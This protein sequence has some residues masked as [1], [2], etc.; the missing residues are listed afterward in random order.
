MKILYFGNERLEAQRFAVALHG[1]AEHGTVSWTSSL[2]RAIKWLDE[3]PDVAALVVE[4]RIDGGTWASVLNQARRPGR[5]PA[6]VL[7]VPEGTGPGVRAMVPG[8]DEYVEKNSPQFLQLPQVVTRAAAASRN[9]H[10][11]SAGL[12]GPPASQPTAPARAPEP[13]RGLAA[14]TS[15]VNRASDSELSRS[16]ALCAELEQ[17]LA[18]ATAALKDAEERHAAAMAASAEQLAERQ[19]Q[20]ELAASR[21]AARWEMVDEQLRAAA[22]E[23]ES[24]RLAHAAAAAEVARL[25]QRESELTTRL[26]ESAA[27]H[28]ALEQR[29]AEVEA[30]GEAAHARSV[31]E[32]RTAAE[33][34]QELQAQIAAEVEARQQIEAALAQAVTARESAA[35]HAQRLDEALC[36]ARIAEASAA[37]EIE[38]FTR[39]EAELASL[40]DEARAAQRNVE[41][42]LA[43]TEAAFQDADVRATSDRLA[44][45]KKAAAREAELDAQ[46]RQERAVRAAL[47][48][49]AAD[50]EDQHQAALAAAAQELADRQ[51]QFDRQLSDSVAERERLLGRL[52]AVDQALAQLQTAHHAAIATADELS[53]R[54]AELTS[55]L[56]GSEVQLAA[57][58]ALREQL[59]SD[60]AATVAS[61]A[62]LTAQSA[63]LEQQI[64]WERT[65]RAALESALSDFE[66]MARET[67]LGYDAALAAAAH[68][69]AVR[70]ARF[71]QVVAGTTADRD[72]LA[73]QLTSLESAF[74]RARADHLAAV[75]EVARLT[76]RETELTTQIDEAG[77]VRAEIERQLREAVA[78]ATAVEADLRGQLTEER[79]TRA[80]VEGA[81]ATAE[82]ALAAAERALAESVN[83]RTAADKRHDAALAAAAIDLAERQAQ[84]DRKLSET[85][86][87]YQRATDQIA[88]LEHSLEDVRV[89]HRLAAAA[90]TRLT[91]RESVLALEIADLSAA[92]QTLERRLADATQ[93]A[94]ARETELAEE[95]RLQRESGAS[96][97]HTIAALEAAAREAQQR[98]ESA[99]TAAAN[100]LAGR[101]REFERLQAEAAAERERA[102]RRL[103]AT[104]AALGAKTGACHAAEAEVARLAAREADLLVRIDGEQNARGAVE[105]QLAEAVAAAA[106]NDEQ[107][108]REK[109]AAASRV[110][111]L[112]ARLSQQIEACST[113]EQL[114]A[115]VRATALESE[116]SFREQAEALRA[117]ASEQREE[118][119]RRIAEQRSAHERQL[120]DAQQAHHAIELAMAEGRRELETAVQRQS[121]EHAAALALRH[122]QIGTLQAQ[123]TSVTQELD[124]TKRHLAAAQTEAARL[125]RVTAQLDESRAERGRLFQQAGHAIFRCTRAGDVTEANRAG[126]TLIGR[127]TIDE[128]RT[129]QFAGVFE[130]PSSLSVLIEHC[131]STR[132]R[133]SI[134]T[135]W[136][137]KDG[138]RLFVRLS[139]YAVSADLIEIVAE[140]VTRLRVLEERLGQAH[141]M[142]AVGR[143]AAE[144]AVTCGNVLADVHGT[145]QDWLR[146]AGTTASR[147]PGEH[148]LAEVTRAAGLLRQLAAYGDEQART[149]SLADLNTV[150]RDL[151]PVLKRVAGDDVEVLLPHT[152]SRLNV[153]V[154]TER[155][156]RLMVNLA[157]YGRTRM[158]FG[159]QLKIELGTTVVDRRFAA[160]HPNARLGPHAVITV[161]EVRRAEPRP[162]ERATTGASQKPGVD[163]G[164]LQELVGAC[165]GHLWMTV[166]PEGETVIKIRLPLVP[167]SREIAPRTPSAPGRGRML[168]RWLQH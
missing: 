133:E 72:R 41:R 105:R 101:Q 153:D 161:T 78:T 73:E 22:I 92:G 148:L 14:R 93:G 30:A 145:V 95:L 137:R 68:E 142:E 31:A 116:R 74:D 6:V 53:R 75:S 54:E 129:P 107:A 27:S 150:I 84:F 124:S 96:L 49:T 4:A 140:D 106:A 61:I 80:A 134:E 10:S 163:F 65:A 109:A 1:I 152:A 51:A 90:V 69:L 76:Q 141:R 135:T 130:D 15:D 64:E 111:D 2:D 44:A 100:E 43:A 35:A 166:Q 66:V 37:A 98:H 67:Q 77:T 48:Q 83:A 50:A 19:V 117:A 25:A 158:P 97:Q 131:L 115:K 132:T 33:Q 60:L 57:A 151:E 155:I 126:M 138:G 91:E 28:H 108:A 17:R 21:T 120:A 102:S 149:P 13:L 9:A 156:E 103:Q 122:T 127:R 34:L 70:Q 94:A 40:L 79:G 168:A 12:L 164:T 8:A 143:L 162:G 18:A 3:N 110:A 38:R 154:G 118:F 157:S 147:Q 11:R 139:A 63:E 5:V 36:A 47:E 165:G 99:L 125:P 23:A 136:R 85:L 45:A 146:M 42:R 86:A 87:A 56:E 59:E 128:L 88:D 104:E 32:Q 62:Q 16:A 167:F 71:D 26:A 114:V 20:F 46:V 7:I 89:S 144:V 24:A 29:L 113:L 112:E 39:R 81:L 123:L 159:G 58:D 121:D 160:K 119:E 55:Q 52:D 82:G